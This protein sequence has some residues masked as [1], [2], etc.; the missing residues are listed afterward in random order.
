LINVL[1]EYLICELEPSKEQTFNIKNVVAGL[2]CAFQ[3]IEV[4]SGTSFN[5]EEKDFIDSLYTVSLRIL[6]QPFNYDLIDILAFLKCTHLVFIIKRQYSAEMI[7]AFAKRLS[8]LQIHM[9]VEEQA[10]LLLLIK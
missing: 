7:A 5:V 8:V 2:L 10:G 3:I 9:P 4:G 1:R 6:E